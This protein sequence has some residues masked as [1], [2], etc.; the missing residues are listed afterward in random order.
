MQKKVQLSAS[1]PPTVRTKLGYTALSDNDVDVQPHDIC[2]ML[3][4]E[5]TKSV[6]SHTTEQPMTCHQPV[7]VQ[8]QQRGSYN[9]RHD[10]GYYHRQLMLKYC[11]AQQ[12]RITVQFY[13]LC[14]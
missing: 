6:G 11:I 12:S 14:G 7:I 1:I 3:K 5:A 8:F 13:T 2:G 10:E 9:K 4:N